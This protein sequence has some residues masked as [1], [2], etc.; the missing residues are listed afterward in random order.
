MLSAKPQQLKRWKPQ[1]D[2][3]RFPEGTQMPKGMMQL[4]RIQEMKHQE[5]KERK[6]RMA[7][8]KD[9]MHTDI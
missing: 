7:R 5:G 1:S 9:G 3:M 4:E 8:D 6:V 2:K